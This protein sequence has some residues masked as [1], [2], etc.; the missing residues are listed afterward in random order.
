MHY[1]ASHKVYRPFDFLQ[2]AE[3]RIDTNETGSM[4]VKFTLRYN[5]IFY[6]KIR[7]L[8]LIR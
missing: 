1:D 4:I 7:D 6:Y 5:E 2:Q 3:M 8:Y